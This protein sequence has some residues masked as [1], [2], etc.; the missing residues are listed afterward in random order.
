MPQIFGSWVFGSLPPQAARHPMTVVADAPRFQ[1]VYIT[2][3]P[4]QIGT[5][6]NWESWSTADQYVD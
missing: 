5:G 4:R 6:N 1:G 2:T 3:P